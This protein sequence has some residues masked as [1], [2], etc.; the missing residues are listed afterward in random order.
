[1][2]RIY[3]IQFYQLINLD[4]IAIEIIQAIASASGLV[5]CAPVTAFVAARFYG[6]G[7]AVNQKTV[8]TSRR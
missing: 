7:N 4:E 6:D 1:M 3:N 8:K 2:F 5:L